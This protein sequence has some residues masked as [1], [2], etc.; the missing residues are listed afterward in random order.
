MSTRIVSGIT[1]FVDIEH[2][3]AAMVDG[4]AGVAIDKASPIDEASPAKA[5]R[6]RLH[7]ELDE[8]IDEFGIENE[9]TFAGIQM[10]VICQD[11]PVRKLHAIRLVAVDQL[12]D[13]SLSRR[14]ER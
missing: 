9:P 11:K 14:L 12:L 5:A 1:P 6:A 2:L 4:S 8:L 7:Q 3:S 13:G 10:D